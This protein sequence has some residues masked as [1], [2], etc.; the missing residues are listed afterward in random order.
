[1]AGLQFNLEDRSKMDRKYKKQ[2]Q[3]LQDKIN[4]AERR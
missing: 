2:I 4:N 3:N 1:M